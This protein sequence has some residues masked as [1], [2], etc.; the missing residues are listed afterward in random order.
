MKTRTLLLMAVGTALAILLAGGVFLVRLAGQA[1]ESALVPIGEAAEVGDVRVTVL[2]A[3]ESDGVMSVDVEI[4]GLDDP[5]GIDS[6]RLVT[7]DRRLAPIGTAATGRCGSITVEVV[8]CRVD[9]DVG[10]AE[11]S[12]RVLV[13]RRGDEQANWRLDRP[14]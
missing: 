13:L 7:G 3:A 8:T 5:D 14:G 10:S 11:G 6:F 1:D 12:S 9:F 4:G 2:G